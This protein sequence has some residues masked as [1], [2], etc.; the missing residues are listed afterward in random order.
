MW[1]DEIHKKFENADESANPAYKEKAWDNM[2]ELLDKHIPVNNRRRRII[3][4]LLLPLLL[5]GSALFFILTKKEKNP[6][7]GQTN[8]SIKS[9]PADIKLSDKKSVMPQPTENPILAPGKKG[10][11]ASDDRFILE[12]KQQNLLITPK[13]KT[14]SGTQPAYSLKT[15]PLEFSSHQDSEEKKNKLTRDVAKNDPEPSIKLQPASTILPEKYTT[16]SI[17]PEKLPA[18]QQM[19]SIEDIHSED[20]ADKDPE[21]RVGQVKN[22]KLKAADKFR[23]NFSFGPDIS[24]AG[25]RNPGK[26]KMQLG[27][28]I[29]YEILN[30]LVLKTGF[31]AGYKIYSADSASY[32]SPYRINRLQKIEANCFIYEIPVN[33]QYNFNS[34]K[35][36]NWFI[37][38]GVS[39]Y[40]MKKET[41]GYFYKNAWGQPQYYKHTYRNKNSHLLAVLNFSG[42]YQHQLSDRLSLMTEP[43]LKIPIQGI[44]V[45]KVKLNSGGILFTVGYKPFVKK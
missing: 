22:S 12:T 40:I 32:H 2:E 9:F 30:H 42:G 27:V 23:I 18:D 39:S 34:T 37:A 6:I 10:I 33:L 35:N 41:Y 44:G 15:T 28:G 25:F 31:F 36:R 24:S 5:T 8:L 20:S 38:G 16:N 14:Q 1:S 43:Y 45:G 17:S 19:I 26:V 21:Q 13:K 3:L 11:A 7:I 4:F 29:S